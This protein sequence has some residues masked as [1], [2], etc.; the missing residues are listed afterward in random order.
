LRVDSVEKADGRS[1]Q[2]HRMPLHPHQRTFPRC[3]QRRS[4]PRRNKRETSITTTLILEELHQLEGTL[5][6][7]PPEPSS[8]SARRSDPAFVRSL[9]ANCPTFDFFLENAKPIFPYKI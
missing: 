5:M 4:D 3:R 8:C 2:S 1:L 7:R 6:T 9:D